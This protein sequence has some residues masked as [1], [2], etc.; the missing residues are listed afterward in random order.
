MTRSRRPA[1]APGNEIQR[2]EK[3][4]GGLPLSL[5]A[6]YD[7]V[8]AV[9]VTGRHT[10]ID[11]PGNTTAPD[12]LVVYGAA[13]ALAEIEGSDDEKPSTIAIAPDDLHK[14]NV[15]GGDPY[16]IA[17]PD[18]RA[19]GI[20]LNERHH[21]LFVDYLRLCFQFGGFPGYEGRDVGVPAELAQLCEGL[22]TF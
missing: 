14:A 15:S 17:V 12:P 6:F 10:G 20:L 13:D 7:V 18:L 11:P 16:E 4:T 19:D 1:R 2:L 5:R 22:L 21:L 9:D 3:I 8:G